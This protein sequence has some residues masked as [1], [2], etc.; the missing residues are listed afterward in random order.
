MFG[1]FG[2]YGRR[3]VGRRLDHGL[4][5]A[6]LEGALLWLREA[7]ASWTTRLPAA[8]CSF[9][10]DYTDLLCPADWWRPMIQR[11]PWQARF[12]DLPPA[13]RPPPGTVALVAVPAVAAWI[14]RSLEGAW[15]GRTVD[16]A[17]PELA[18]EDAAPA[19][20]P[21]RHRRRPRDLLSRLTARCPCGD[22]PPPATSRGVAEARP[23]VPRRQWAA[24]LALAAA[25]ADRDVEGARRALAIV[26][27]PAD[28]ELLEALDEEA[29]E[30]TDT[31]G[32]PSGLV[33]TGGAP[34]SW[35]SWP[36][37]R[38]WAAASTVQAAWRAHA[39]LSTLAPGLREELR[40]A[41]AARLLV[42]AVR[43][44]PTHA[45][46]GVAVAAVATARAVRASATLSLFV[47]ADD[48]AALAS[49]DQRRD[50]PQYAFSARGEL[51]FVSPEEDFMA[52]SRG[53]VPAWAAARAGVRVDMPG[54]SDR[55]I[56]SRVIEPTGIAAP[57][58]RWLAPL[59][60]AGCRAA[61]DGVGTRL[62]FP[63][64]AEAAGRAFAAAVLSRGLVTL[65]PAPAYGAGHDVCDF[66]SLS[67]LRPHRVPP[68]A[69]AVPPLI[70]DL[71]RR[72]SIRLAAPPVPAA[73]GG[74]AL[75]GGQGGGHGRPTPSAT[76]VSF[77][78][79]RRR[80]G[81]AGRGGGATTMMST[82]G[83]PNLGDDDALP[84]PFTE[85]SPEAAASPLGVALGLLIAP[86]RPASPQVAPAPPPPRP[87]SPPATLAPAPPQPA[88]TRPPPPV[89]PARAA[90][91]EVARAAA[92]EAC[93]MAAAARTAAAAAAER[94]ARTRAE[95]VR[96][97]REEEAVLR[98]DL[99]RL[100]A[101]AAQD[102]GDA[103]RNSRRRIRDHG[104]AGAEAAAEARRV[105]TALARASAD[106]ARGR[107][108]ARELGSSVARALLGNARARARAA[109]RAAEAKKQH[110]ATETVMDRRLALREG[111]ID[112]AEL[113]RS[114]AEGVGE[115]ARLERKAR[116][117]ALNGL[118]RGEADAAQAKAAARRQV[119]GTRT[120][121][122]RVPLALRR[123]GHDVPDAD[124]G[125]DEA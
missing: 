84:V 64:A 31:V 27:A 37:A 100:W 19:N 102:R 113:R 68:P 11:R 34:L 88:P 47:S 62:I 117:Q 8:E 58:G 123:V 57:S 20:P 14:E 109:A 87:P 38:R 18:L 76:T 52:A 93:E 97:R 72:H 114:V 45:R 98:S 85:V 49:T 50:S 124:D 16:G 43:A 105:A 104:A 46:V 51:F 12:S 120:R 89:L 56:D 73:L 82:T 24:A 17:A 48:A 99:E 86:H 54:L 66:A 71:C 26:L 75:F 44:R 9:L 110:A 5:G 6:P 33:E 29:A 108:E 81:A 36:D 96:R 1:F 77:V 39:A 91:A 107:R 32:G 106:E 35:L 53:R 116:D 65:G 83:K 79:L 15:H 30:L 69:P 3:R 119:A 122:G 13:P 78:P 112:A 125:V 92:T 90:A 63:S 41:R 95:D 21:A 25:E 2:Q 42:R 4:G 28:S 115:A 101:A 7:S 40:R 10:F 111:L 23:L 22:S 118:A 70:A 80:P 121:P 74:A 94:E 55:V 61:S 103:V 59:L 60:L 67:G